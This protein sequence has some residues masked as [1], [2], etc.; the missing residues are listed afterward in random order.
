MRRQPVTDLPKSPDLR[1]EIPL[2]ARGVIAVA[3]LDEAGRGAWAGP[4]SA[5]AVILPP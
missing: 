5:A 3:G 1:F 4:V 2:W